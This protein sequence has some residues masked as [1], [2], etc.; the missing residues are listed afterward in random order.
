MDLFAREAWNLVNQQLP[1]YQ[2]L[3]SG[4]ETREAAIHPITILIKLSMKLGIK[5]LELGE[6][7]FYGILK[8][9]RLKC[10]VTLTPQ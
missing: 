5:V 1:E 4:T 10:H 8:N 3:I 2:E 9:P 6:K 7:Y